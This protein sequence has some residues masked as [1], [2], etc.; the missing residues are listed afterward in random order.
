[1]TVLEVLLEVL[2]RFDVGAEHLRLAVGHEHDAVRTLEHQLARFVVEHLSRD[3]VEL[4]S[5]V[6]P[7]NA[8]DV[9]REEV[10]EDRPIAF[11]GERDHLAAVTTFEVIVNPLQVGCLSTQARPVIHD[12]GVELAQRIV[13]EDHV[14][15]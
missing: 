14:R 6:H 13:E 12:F 5:D 11:G 3:G 15:P 2:E 1:M 9:D 10:E 8:P 4:E 7:P